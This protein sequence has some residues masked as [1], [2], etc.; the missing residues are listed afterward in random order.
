MQFDKYKIATI[1]LT[2]LLVTS[3][4]FLAVLQ[5]RSNNQTEQILT[6]QKT[7]QEELVRSSSQ[8]VSREELEK[9]I[10]MLQVSLADVR[11][12]LD[13][14]GYNLQAVVS[15]STKTPG[16][17]QGNLP[18]TSTNPKSGTEPKVPDFIPCSDGICVNPDKF[19]YLNNSQTLKLSEPFKNN[20]SIPFGETTF[21]AWKEHPWELK[22]FPREYKS[23]TILSVNEDGK[24]VAHNQFLIETEGK[25]Y[26]LPVQESSLLEIKPES[27][28]RFSPRL[29]LGFDV[30]A[31]IVRTTGGVHPGASPNL[32]VSLFSYG[33]TK[34]D[35]EWSFVGLG[36]GYLVD[37]QR[38][39][40]LLS[41]VNYNVGHHLPLMDNLHVGPSVAVDTDANFTVMGGLRVGL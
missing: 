13:N 37:E 9:Y 33:Q 2:I 34:K 35:V 32:Q 41:P 8:T 4:I 3:L 21:N 25:I 38:P 17:Y 23:V 12:D 6:E 29:Y 15:N 11:D 19:G 16:S 26:K 20:L 10:L 1:V 22:V 28:F 40:L 36:V 30:G 5:V 18:S 27:K 39:A 14:L 7:L 31:T 24:H